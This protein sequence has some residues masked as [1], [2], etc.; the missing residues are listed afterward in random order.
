MRVD[1]YNTK[2]NPSTPPIANASFEV[3]EVL[4]LAARELAVG[5]LVALVMGF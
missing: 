5:L 1:R 4:S 3:Q 2:A